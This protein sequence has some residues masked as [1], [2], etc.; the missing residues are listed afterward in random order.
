MDTFLPNCTPDS[1][2]HRWQI[3]G[4]QLTM[5]LPDVCI[6]ILKHVFQFDRTA[7]SSYCFNLHDLP[8]SR[9]D[10]RSVFIYLR[11]PRSWQR[12]NEIPLILFVL[13]FLFR[14]APMACGSSGLEVESELQL[15]SYAS[16]T[17]AMDPSCLC[18]PYR[19][20]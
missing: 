15:S 11:E 10:R 4:T 19:S 12:L 14:A 1:E 16:V 9:V 2:C 18:D 20:S 6:I 5:P 13:C 17:A 7:T 3:Q 8:T